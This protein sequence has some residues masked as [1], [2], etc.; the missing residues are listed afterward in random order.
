MGNNYWLPPLAWRR[1]GVNAN[2]LQVIEDL[3]E[4]KSNTFNSQHAT[5][6]NKTMKRFS[7]NWNWTHEDTITFTHHTIPSG[8]GTHSV[9]TQSAT[10]SMFVLVTIN[11]LIRVECQNDRSIVLLVLDTIKLDSFMQWLGDGSQNDEDTMQLQL[12]NVCLCDRECVS[13]STKTRLKNAEKNENCTSS[14]VRSINQGKIRF[15]SDVN[16]II[17][18]DVL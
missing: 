6:M 3:M 2:E 18:F 8:S 7:K 12:G 15:H 9:G 1:A 10:I 17:L 11:V 5:K 13:H 4:W 16:Y 14:G